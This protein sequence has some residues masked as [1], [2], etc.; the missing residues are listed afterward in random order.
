MSKQIICLRYGIFEDYGVLSNLTFNNETEIFHCHCAQ[1][2]ISYSIGKPVLN[3]FSFSI[4]NAPRTL[5]TVRDYIEWF[6]YNWNRKKISISTRFMSS[7]FITTSEI[8]IDRKKSNRFSVSHIHFRFNCIATF[9]N[10]K[11]LE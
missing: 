2:A 6:S 10:S 3:F 1:C 4:V 9:F 7:R 5:I 11:C 8:I